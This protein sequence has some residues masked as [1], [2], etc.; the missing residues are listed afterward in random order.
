MYTSLTLLFSLPRYSTD[1]V[2]LAAKP[3]AAAP[4][5]SI[6]AASPGCVFFGLS[7]RGLSH[8]SLARQGWIWDQ[9]A[10]IAANFECT[11]PYF[12]EAT[13]QDHCA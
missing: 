13:K 9:P 7:G 11:S 12:R 10:A 8:S 4:A 6:Q 3:A 5:A 2:S 1:G